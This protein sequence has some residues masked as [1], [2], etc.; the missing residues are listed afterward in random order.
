[1][2]RMLDECSTNAERIRNRCA[3]N[4]SHRTKN[5]RIRN[6]CITNE[7]RIQRTAG[8]QETD[9]DIHGRILTNRTHKTSRVDFTG[10]FSLNANLLLLPS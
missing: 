5:E 7:Y 1:M 9:S 4:E 3:A 10:N 6:R 2:E 8:A